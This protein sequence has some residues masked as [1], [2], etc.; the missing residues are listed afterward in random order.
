M[1]LGPEALTKLQ[2]PAKLRDL[3]VSPG[4]AEDLFTRRV[5]AER[6]STIGR[7][8][9]SLCVS[10]NVANEI[11]GILREKALL[12]Y[13]GLDGRDY[14]ITLTEL[15][16]RNTAERMKTGQHV[17]SMPVPIEDYQTI[18]KL[19]QNE[20]HLDRSLVKKA[21]SDMGC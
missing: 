19:Q 3:G 10:H 11:A 14:R 17:A 9:E 15:G 1:G 13:Q 6:T 4:L 20:I 21:F 8:A 16:Y 7:V 5:L 12:E 18:V 2:A